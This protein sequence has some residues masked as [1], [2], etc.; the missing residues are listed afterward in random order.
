YPWWFR[1]SGNSAHPVV[2]VV[3]RSIEYRPGSGQ[4]HRIGG[5]LQ[6]HAGLP[7]GNLDDHPIGAE[8]GPDDLAVRVCTLHGQSAAVA[9]C[10][11]SA[12]L[13][14]A[15]QTPGHRGTSMPG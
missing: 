9:G 6:D 7:D 14:P 15:H 13:S 4:H 3:A 8:L 1:P 11:W 5:L 2:R 12:Y 10:P